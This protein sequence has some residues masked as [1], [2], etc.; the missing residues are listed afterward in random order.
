MYCFHC[1]SIKKKQLLDILAYKLFC[2]GV[3]SMK[4]EKKIEKPD[5]FCLLHLDMPL[6]DANKMLCQRAYL[7]T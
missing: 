5:L 6:T 3:I 2:V 7:L 4:K 1:F